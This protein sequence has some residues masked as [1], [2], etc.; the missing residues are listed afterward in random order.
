MVCKDSCMELFFCPDEHDNRYIN[1][2]INPNGCT[3]IGISHRR[4][5]IVRL[6]PLNEE[7]LFNKQVNRTAGRHSFRFRSLFCRYFSL[8]T[9][10]CLGERSGQ[11][12]TNVEI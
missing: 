8:I 1:F 10:L 5:D 6:C 2:E 12:A 9:R 11:T 7:K 4:T 3:F